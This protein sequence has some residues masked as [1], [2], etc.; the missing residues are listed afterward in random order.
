MSAKAA[1]F[2]SNRLPR[3]AM[4]LLCLLMAQMLVSLS[5]CHEEPLPMGAVRVAV[6]R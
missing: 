1:V 4:A 3:P 6:S 2:V 5:D